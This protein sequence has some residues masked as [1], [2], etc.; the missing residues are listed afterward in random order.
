M[1]TYIAEAG[2]PTAEGLKLLS[3]WMEEPAAAEA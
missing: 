2:S 1:V 3:S